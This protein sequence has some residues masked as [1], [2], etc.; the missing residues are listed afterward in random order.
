MA[1]NTQ[2]L[3]GIT[4]V[5]GVSY[6]C[7]TP[8]LRG[9]EAAVEAGA[10]EVAIFAAASETFSKK[11]INASIEESLAR[12][13][14]VCDA[15]REKNIKV[16]GYVSCVLGC[17]YEITTPVSKVVE[18]SKRLYDLGCYEISLGDTIGVGTP[19][20]TFKLLQAV[21]SQ[22]P[23]S[24]IAVHFHDTYGQ[25]LANILTSLQYGVN[26]VDSSVSGLGGCP[27]AKGA[28]GNVATEDV[29][30][31]M[32]DL[33]INCGV[34]MEKLMETSLWISKL[35]GRSPSSKVSLALS[36]KTNQQQQQ[37]TSTIQNDSKLQQQQQQ[38]QNQPHQKQFFIPNSCPPS[39]I[40]DDTLKSKS[41]LLFN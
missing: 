10:K 34:D 17:P 6:P 3:R 20:A 15:A 27:Y 33:G 21:S 38:Q 9:F 30:Y 29:L 23:L 19:G 26:V 39:A 7:L 36:H 2:V 5:D 22:I 37:I 4:Q 41:N 11:N 25:A 18:V 16:R 1:D 35:L 40:Q 14:D 12:Y 31:M 8:N 32:K 28:T 24:A 13:K